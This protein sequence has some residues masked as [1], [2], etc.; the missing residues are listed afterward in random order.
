MQFSNQFNLFLLGPSLGE[1]QLIIIS[2]GSK[3]GKNFPLT[4]VN[5]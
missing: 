1:A 5:Q 3:N 2:R 4:H